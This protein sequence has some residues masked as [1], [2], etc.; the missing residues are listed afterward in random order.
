MST[1][2]ELIDNW[3]IRGFQ[4]ILP[5]WVGTWENIKQAKGNE[6]SQYK[7]TTAIFSSSL[8]ICP[9]HIFSSD[10]HA[11]VPMP[12]NTPVEAEVIL[13]ILQSTTTRTPQHP[14]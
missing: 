11:C 4:W 8:P 13:A 12:T 2:L 1:P 10:T 6:G 5:W 14:T 7:S 9:I 3:A